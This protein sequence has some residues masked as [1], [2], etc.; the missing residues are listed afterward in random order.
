M[1][2]TQAKVFLG[3]YWPN[4]SPLPCARIWIGWSARHSWLIKGF[5][6]PLVVTGLAMIGLLKKLWSICQPGWRG[7]R[8]AFP[9]IHRVRLQWRIQGRGHSP[10]S[11]IFRPKWGPKGRKKN[12][13]RAPLM[14]GWSP[15]PPRAHLKVWIRHWVCDAGYQPG[16][17]SF[18]PSGEE[19]ETAV[20]FGF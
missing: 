11:L 16:L 1:Y 17:V 7:V 19:P 15:P 9:V 12:W 13:E 2:N 8:N 6:L 18:L 3:K 4:R 20:F 5:S 10:P 14:S